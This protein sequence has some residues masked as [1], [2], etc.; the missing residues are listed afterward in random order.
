MP[1]SAIALLDLVQNRIITVS[2]NVTFS[3]NVSFTKIPTINGVP[4]ENSSNKQK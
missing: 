1:N 4:I 3:G 2:N